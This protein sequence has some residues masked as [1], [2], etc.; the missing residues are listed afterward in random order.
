MVNSSTLKAGEGGATIEEDPYG[1]Q[2]G[3]EEIMDIKEIDA[4][5]AGT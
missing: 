4:K 2:G 5:F 3:Q 1:V